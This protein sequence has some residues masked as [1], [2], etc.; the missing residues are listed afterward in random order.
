M[1]SQGQCRKDN[2]RK[3]DL[4]DSSA[5]D[6]TRFGS[7]GRGARA[8]E[9]VKRLGARLGNGSVKGSGKGSGRNDDTGRKGVGGGEWE[10]GVGYGRGRHKG[11]GGSCP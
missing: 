11:G 4:D 1:S 3:K 10:G 2:V 6:S 7:I 5:R 8:I 9:F